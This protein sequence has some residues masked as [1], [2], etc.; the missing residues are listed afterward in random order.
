M[1]T[2]YYLRRNICP[3]C[4]RRDDD[5]HIGKSSF[6]WCFLLHVYPEDG[7]HDLPDWERLWAQ[8]GARIFDEYGR[9]VSVADMREVITE[10]GRAG[11]PPDRAFYEENEAQPGPN[12]LARHRLDRRFVIGHGDGPW[13]LCAR[14]FS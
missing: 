2:N 1:G 5:L 12:G 4:G 8:A 14:D 6:G 3:H 7:I 9:E 11:P 10:R 13:D